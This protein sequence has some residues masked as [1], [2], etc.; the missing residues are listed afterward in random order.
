[1]KTQSGLILQVN[2]LAKFHRRE[3]YSGSHGKCR[4]KDTKEYIKE[5]IRNHFGGE[6]SSSMY[7][8]AFNECFDTLRVG[9]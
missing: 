2:I 8:K 9:I 3:Q 5:I 6:H 4:P 1:M 7:H